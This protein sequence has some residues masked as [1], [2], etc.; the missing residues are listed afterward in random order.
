ME[1][2]RKEVPLLGLVLL[3]GEEGGGKVDGGGEGAVPAERSGR[4]RDGA[5][6][7]VAGASA[8]QRDP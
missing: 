6:R 1:H 3:V 7:D 5:G 4:E 2:P 8:L